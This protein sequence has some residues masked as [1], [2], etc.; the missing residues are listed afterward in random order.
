MADVMEY[1]EGRRGEDRRTGCVTALEGALARLRSEEER[2]QVLA[3]KDLWSLSCDD[4]QLAIAIGQCAPILDRLLELCATA[5]TSAYT[6]APGLPAQ[7]SW[8]LVV[9]ALHCLW[10]LAAYE[11]NKPTVV[12]HGTHAPLVWFASSMVPMWWFIIN[13]IRRGGGGPVPLQSCSPHQGQVPQRGNSRNMRIL[14]R[15][16]SS[17]SFLFCHRDRHPELSCLPGVPVLQCHPPE[18]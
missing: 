4:P 6:R 14:L 17:L 5:S 13:I 1:T 7:P 16:L 15:S 2:D 3:I 12:L 8:K 11:E 9:L 10:N 18:R